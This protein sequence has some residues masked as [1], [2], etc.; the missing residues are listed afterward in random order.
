MQ[1]HQNLTVTGRYYPPST[2]PSAIDYGQ[3]TPYTWN[4]NGAPQDGVRLV[5]QQAPWRA[6]FVALDAVAARFPDEPVTRHQEADAI[7]ACCWLH[8]SYI[9]VLASGENY[10]PFRQDRM[11]SRISEPEM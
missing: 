11:L 5:P 2:L 7:V 10:P 6:L 1:Q 8:G 4:N 9:R 3:W